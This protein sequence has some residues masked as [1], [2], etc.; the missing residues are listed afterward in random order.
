MIQLRQVFNTKIGLGLQLKI[1]KSTICSLFTCDSESW[2][3]DEKT[4]T[5]LNE[6]NARLMSHITGKTCHLEVSP[7]THTFDLVGVIRQHVLFHINL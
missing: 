7:R 6:V 2:F 4:M 3:L 5:T 1:Y